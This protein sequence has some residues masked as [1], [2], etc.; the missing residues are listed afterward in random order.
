MPGATGYV[1]FG[2]ACGGGNRFEQITDLTGTSYNHT[3]LKK[4]TY[5]KFNVVAYQ[6]GAGGVKK[7]IAASRTVHVATKKGK[8]TNYKSVKV[9]KKKVTLKVKEKFNL[10]TNLVLA[11]KKLKVKNHRKISF[12]SRCDGESK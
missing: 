3:G 9:N 7:V 6:T 2:N 10:T 4:G 8:V 11:D 5:Y 1:V 12:E